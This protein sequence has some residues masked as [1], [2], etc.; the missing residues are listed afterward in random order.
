MKI[1]VFADIHGSVDGMNVALKIFSVEKPNKVVFCGDL[2]SGW[3]GSSEQIAQMAQSMDSVLYFVRGN[4]DLSC[5]DGLLANGFEDSAV[6]HHFNRTLFFTHGDRYNG[7][8]VP[9]ILQQGDAIIHG[10]THVGALLRRNGLYV[11]NVG[12]LAR[13]RDKQPCYLVLDEQ[14]ATLKRPEGAILYHLPWA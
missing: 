13:P 11:L 14:G 10:H 2:F 5:Y 6:M 8:H 9:P 7:F 3:S 12:S 4:N 1:V